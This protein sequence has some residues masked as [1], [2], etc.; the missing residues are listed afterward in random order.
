MKEG[1][2]NPDFIRQIATDAER[3]DLDGSPQESVARLIGEAVE[4]LDAGLA[5]DEAA[6]ALRAKLEAAHELAKQERWW[7]L[8]AGTKRLLDEIKRR[9]P[10][11]REGDHS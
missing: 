8:D 10:A 11:I 1:V 2:P 4:E 7:E 5:S 9:Y 6:T 3:A